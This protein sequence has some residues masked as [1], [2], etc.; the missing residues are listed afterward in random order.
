M[1]LDWQ[2]FVE[3]PDYIIAEAAEEHMKKIKDL[4]LEMGLEEDE[5]LLHGH[6]VAKV[7]YLKV[8]KRLENKPDGKYIDVTAITPTPP[9]RG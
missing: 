9:G 1:G 6:Y 5:L 7:D 3:E 4:G 2:K 8:L